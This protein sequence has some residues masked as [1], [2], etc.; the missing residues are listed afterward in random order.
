M[1]FSQFVMS[2]VGLAKNN[3]ADDVDNDDNNNDDYKDK[4]RTVILASAR[5]L[6][7]VLD[8]GRVRIN[9]NGR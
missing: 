6:R 7:K 1:V 5:L 4:K 2:R 9:G 8:R 3:Y